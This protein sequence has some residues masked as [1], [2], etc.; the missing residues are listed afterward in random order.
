MRGERMKSL[1]PSPNTS[2]IKPYVEQSSLKTNWQLAEGLLY[3]QG[4]IKIHT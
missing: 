1:R 3:N 2:K 4:C